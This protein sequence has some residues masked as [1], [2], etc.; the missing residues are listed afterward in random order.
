MIRKNKMKIFVF[1]HFGKFGPQK[2][3]LAKND[4]K[5]IPTL[6]IQ[7]KNPYNVNVVT[8]VEGSVIR[9]TDCGYKMRLLNSIFVFLPSFQTTLIHI[10][11]ET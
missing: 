10:N 4:T 2:K 1:L 8:I 11:M 5:K 7:S 6:K 9:E 3:I